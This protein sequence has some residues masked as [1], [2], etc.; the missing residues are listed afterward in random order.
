M[1]GYLSTSSRML[2]WYQNDE[3]A[4]IFKMPPN[5]I[6]NFN[7]MHNDQSS[8]QV[9]IRVLWWWETLK[10]VCNLELPPCQ[11]GVPCN[12]EMNT[13]IRNKTSA[14]MHVLQPYIFAS[15]CMPHAHSAEIRPH[16]QN[17]VKLLKRTPLPAHW[18]CRQCVLPFRPS[19]YL[20]ANFA[21][22]H[23]LFL[24]TCSWWL[25]QLMVDSWFQIWC[26]LLGGGFARLQLWAEVWMV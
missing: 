14:L 2:C 20:L 25:C 1:E 21:L 11:L 10:V 24:Q 15:E 19:C 13:V 22:Q 5:P 18:R 12:T 7:Y 23:E 6:F 9:L 16:D 17:W 26:R 3:L 8:D 4:I